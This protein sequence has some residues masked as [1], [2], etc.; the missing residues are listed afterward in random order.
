LNKNQV[1]TPTWTIKII[2]ALGQLGW[3]L[4]AFAATTLLT[5]FYL[6]PEIGD[7]VLASE[8]EDT[9][10][11]PS[12]IFQGALLG[13]VTVIGLLNFGGRLF[14]AITDPIIA[15]MSDRWK[16]TPGRRTPFLKF[17]AIPFALFSVLVFVPLS[18]EESV[19]NVIWLAF[20]LFGFYF[21]MTVYV[22]PYTAWMSELGH[23]PNER[24]NISTLISITYA[25]GFAIGNTVHVIQKYLEDQFLLSSTNA[26]QITIIIYAGLALCLM[27]LPALL[28]N[29]TKYS[30]Q[31]SSDLTALQSVKTV[32]KDK[33]F[34]VFAFSDFL[35]WMAFTS[36]LSGMAYYVT[37]LV[38]QGNEKITEYTLIILGLSFLFY[39][40]INLITKKVG[41]KQMV[42]LSFAVYILVFIGMFFI[43]KVSIPENIHLL[44]LV[45]ISALPIAVFGILPNAIIAD[46]ADADA[47]K[48]GENKAGMY[49]GVRMFMMKLGIS[50]TNFVFPALLIFGKSTENDLGVRLTA[51]FACLIC[52]A[53]W[54]V[55]RQF[56]EVKLDKN[57]ESRI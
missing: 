52:I 42:S 11:F 43:G 20:T 27:L 2:Y 23:N 22:T 28:I 14:D 40:P 9:A 48:T 12:Y 53:G 50:A 45:V 26:F 49:F 7:T 32:F 30:I 44:I 29:E 13:F 41:K 31:G 8:S 16:R 57:I 54:L 5:Y 35:Y 51:G 25:L 18:P 15:N 6:P 37:I 4:C 38:K 56:K 1:V 34:K 24:L 3:S 21:F 17:G 55:F 39:I 19:L 10:I 36:I 47:L 33:N 46:L